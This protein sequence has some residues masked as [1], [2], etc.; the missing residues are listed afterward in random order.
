MR[1]VGLDIAVGDDVA[2]ARCQRLRRPVATTTTTT[3]AATRRAANVDINRPWAF[4]RARRLARALAAALAGLA[5]A[6]RVDRPAHDGN[7]DRALRIIVHHAVDGD[8]PPSIEHAVGGPQ[9]IRRRDAR[10]HQTF[11]TERHVALAV[12]AE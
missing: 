1:V 10:R 3:T 6:A 2:R 12:G 9:L 11:A 7:A 8:Q 4:D 5:V